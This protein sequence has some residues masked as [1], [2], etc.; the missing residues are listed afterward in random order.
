MQL[1]VVRHGIA[2][3]HD[4]WAKEHSDDTERPL[5]AEGKKKMKECAKGLRALVP[6]VG[7]DRI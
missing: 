1:L 3:D 4:E 6:R 7:H 5:T 2:V